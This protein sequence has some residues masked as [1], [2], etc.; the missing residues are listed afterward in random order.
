MRRPHLIGNGSSRTS[1]PVGT[2]NGS[3]MHWHS[4]AD[5][6]TMVPGIEGVGI[7]RAVRRVLYLIASSHTVVITTTSSPPRNVLAGFKSRRCLFS[8]PKPDAREDH[9]GAQTFVQRLW[10]SNGPS[11]KRGSEPKRILS[12]TRSL[13]QLRSARGPQPT[14]PIR[15]S[16]SSRRRRTR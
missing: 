16:T 4:R 2:I 10:A 15:R 1:R 5:G 3:P 7:K 8:V 9:H 14:R 12:K 6:A 13:V 11:E